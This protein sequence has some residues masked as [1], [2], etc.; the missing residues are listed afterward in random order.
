MF[1]DTSGPISST[2][3]GSGSSAGAILTVA[4]PPSVALSSAPQMALGATTTLTISMYFA[5]LFLVFLWH[6]VYKAVWFEG[7][8][9][10]GVGSLVILANTT[11]LS[12]YTFSCHSFRHLVGGS[13]NSYSEAPLGM[14]RHKIWST[15]SEN[16]Q[17]YSW[18]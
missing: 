13:V 8:F 1:D 6:D 15:V 10:V 7:H 16:W 11:F 5:L 12:L 3:G 18:R 17:R 9:G 14:L 2:E 4:T